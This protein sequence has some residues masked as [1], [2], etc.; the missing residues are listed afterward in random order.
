MFGWFMW[1]KFIILLKVIGV[2]MFEIIHPDD[3]KKMNS[4]SM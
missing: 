4:N 2:K 1:M 3:N